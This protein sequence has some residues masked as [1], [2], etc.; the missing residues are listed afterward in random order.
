MTQHILTLNNYLLSPASQFLND[1][2]DAI[3]EYAKARKIHSAARKTVKEL[4]ALNNRELNDIGIG[5]GDIQS[6]AYG[7][8]TLLR[9]V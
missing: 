7:D 6:I 3:R 4:S 5:R 2:I 1:L 9:N 8:K